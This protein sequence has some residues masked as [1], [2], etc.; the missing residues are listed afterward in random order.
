M[1]VL[2]FLIFPALVHAVVHCLILACF[3]TMTYCVCLCM[4]LQDP[5]IRAL[6]TDSRH[7]FLGTAQSGPWGY[8]L[9]HK[10]RVIA[11]HPKNVHAH[12]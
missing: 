11:L 10:F 5:C 9:G 4:L 6:A 12:I 7:S 2:T 3:L 1:F 8:K